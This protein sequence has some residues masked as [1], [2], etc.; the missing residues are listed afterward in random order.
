MYAAELERHLNET[1]N[2]D[3]TTVQDSAKC[4]VLVEDIVDFLRS[5]QLQK[6]QHQKLVD[7]FGNWVQQDPFPSL[8]PA[9]A[10]E[11][12]E[13]T[14]QEDRTGP[15]PN[16]NTEDVFHVEEIHG[17]VER[18]HRPLTE[19]ELGEQEGWEEELRSAG[20]RIDGSPEWYEQTK[21]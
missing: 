7:T 2:V 10:S 21:Q 4:Q 16:E 11:I 12:R 20:V 17:Q 9:V 18:M 13:G 1:L 6:S 19:E 14:D 8:A 5:G 3:N 15:F